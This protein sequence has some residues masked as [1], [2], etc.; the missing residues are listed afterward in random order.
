M[1]KQKSNKKLTA[2]KFVID[3]PV[4]AE[5][6]SVLKPKW[7]GIVLGGN[8]PELREFK[9]LHKFAGK[10][11]GETLYKFIVQWNKDNKN[12]K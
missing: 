11:V 4:K 12:L 8:S 9:G 5:T 2:E 3:K 10:S 6:K 1:A 7:N